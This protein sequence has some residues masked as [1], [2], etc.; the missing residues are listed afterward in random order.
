MIQGHV[1]NSLN[2]QVP[3]KKIQR[4]GRQEC[5]IN[6]ERIKELTTRD[7]DNDYWHSIAKFRRCLQ[8]L[9]NNR[10]IFIDEAAVYYNTYPHRAL[11]A[12][13]NQPLVLLE[14]PSACSQRFDLIG[15]STDPNQLPVWF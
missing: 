4:Y 5:G 11:V 8:R 12:P 1:E 3:L 7:I 9:A 6:S 15:P 2:K 13:Q 10:L 14:K